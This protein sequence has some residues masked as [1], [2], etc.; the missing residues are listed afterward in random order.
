[1]K[2]KWAVVRILGNEL[3][4]RDRPGSRLTTLDYI[5][6]HEPP[7]EDADKLWVLNRVVEP[8]LLTNYELMLWNHDY[9][10]DRVLELSFSPT[11]YVAARTFKQKVLAAIGINNARNQAIAWAHE[12]GYQWVL[13]LDGDCMWQRPDWHNW[14][15]QTR[16]HEHRYQYFSVPHCR[17]AVCP[18]GMLQIDLTLQ[19]CQIAFSRG[20]TLRFDETLPFG[21]DDKLSL[22]RVLGHTT[23]R[24]SGAWQTMPNALTKMIP[25]VIH[26]PT[27]D[28]AT[29][30]D[31]R[32]RR[33]QRER[34][35]QQLVRSLDSTFSV[36]AAPLLADSG[37]PNPED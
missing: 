18:E 6:Q 5:L 8:Q 4:P 25:R 9:G 26:L 36:L 15:K 11:E 37:L 10:E 12:L 1:M 32:H 19:E 13:I 35:L 23:G 29:E 20:S 30:T 2:P 22:L 17:A 3:V 27:G 7:L 34:S 16:L 24:E 28:T 14:L 33:E 21:Q 31:Q